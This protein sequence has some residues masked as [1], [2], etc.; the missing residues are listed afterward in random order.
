MADVV[1]HSEN[2]Q[3]EGNLIRSERGPIRS[4]FDT[5]RYRAKYRNYFLAALALE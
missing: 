4:A 3:T 1:H 2:S 5:S